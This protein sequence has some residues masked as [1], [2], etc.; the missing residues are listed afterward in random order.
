MDEQVSAHEIKV[1]AVNRGILAREK[2][3][4]AA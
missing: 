3:A 2:I 4:A 1:K